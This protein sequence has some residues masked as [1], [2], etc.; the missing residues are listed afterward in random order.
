MFGFARSHSAMLTR[1]SMWVKVRVWWMFIDVSRN[2]VSRMLKSAG[3]RP[4][5]LTITQTL[6]STHMGQRV[7]MAEW[8]LANPNILD[9]LWFSDEAHFYLS[10]HVNS[11]NSVHWGLTRPDKVLTKHQFTPKT[12]TVWTAYEKVRSWSSHS[13]LKMKTRNQ[14]PLTRKTVSTG[15]WNHLGKF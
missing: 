10:G 7:R 13:S 15:L 3:F 9:R 8:L 12:V 5:H 1:C 11:H 2:S 4:Y 14:S 6:T